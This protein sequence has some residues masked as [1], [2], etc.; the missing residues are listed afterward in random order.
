MSDLLS[1]QME[2]LNQNDKMLNDLYHHYAASLNLSDTTLWVLYIAW[3]EG[4]G[5][6]Q[7]EICE[8][9][10]YTKQ[11]I[12]TAL[13]NLEKRGYIRLVPMQENRKSKQIEFTKEG[14]AFAQKIVPP[15]LKAEKVSFGNLT[16]Q[17]RAALVSLSQKRAELLQAEMEKAIA[18]IK[19]N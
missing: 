11:T 16:E 7:K 2:L 14:K 13:K 15:L 4:D 10:S 5:C 19:G 6:T 12:N 17:E 8:S 3:I 9:W 18:S 1:Q